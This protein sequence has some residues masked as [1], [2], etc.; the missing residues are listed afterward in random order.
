MNQTDARPF[1]MGLALNETWRLMI[2]K[3]LHVF[4]WGL[5]LTLPS[6][7]M[8]MVMYGLMGPLTLAQLGN[9]NDPALQAVAKQINTVSWIV[10]IIALAAMVLVGKAIIEHIVRSDSAHPWFGL[11][12]DMQAVRSFVVLLAVWIG[13]FILVALI[14]LIAILIGA[15]LASMAGQ[16]AGVLTGI[17]I[18]LIGLA[19]MVWAGIRVSL[20]LPASIGLK[21]FAF[22]QGWKAAKGH[23]WPLLGLAVIVCLLYFA[24]AIAMYFIGFV[25]VLA[26]ALGFHVDQSLPINEMIGWGGVIAVCVAYALFAAVF[27]GITYVL[28]FGP[29]ASVWKQMALNAGGVSDIATAE[30]QL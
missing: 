18:G 7:P 29:F 15:A 17:L 10:Q 25:I 13:W 3:P 2:K 5:V 14:A 11:K 16:V 24:V 4:I 9:E 19:V 28:Y 20:I 30:H 26:T 23:F 12:P 1:D 8:F 21:D 22:V 27:S 6:I